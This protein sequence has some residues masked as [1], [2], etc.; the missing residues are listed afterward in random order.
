ME[1]IHAAT[2][3]ICPVYIVTYVDGGTRKKT[4][5]GSPSRGRDQFSGRQTA[6]ISTR[7]L[8]GREN[9]RDA[10]IAELKQKQATL[11]QSYD[12]GVAEQLDPIIKEGQRLERLLR[13]DWAR[14]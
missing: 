2:I 13:W 1:Y 3:F 10:S 4:L 8:L 14:R 12:E 11:E 9:Q 5:Q 7:K 6:W